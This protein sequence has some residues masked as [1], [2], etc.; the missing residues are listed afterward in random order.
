MN[1]HSCIKCGEKYEDEDVE[2]YY[3][4]LCNEARKELAKKIDAQFAH[5]PKVEPMSELQAYDAAQKV[6]GI[7]MRVKL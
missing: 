6:R 1:T 2:A 4:S 3:C 7:F 5:L